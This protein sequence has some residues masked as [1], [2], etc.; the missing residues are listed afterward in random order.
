MQAL[1]VTA[2][3]PHLAMLDVADPVPL[4]D[5]ALVR[6][7]AF[8]L[9]RGEVL[10]LAD[11]V[12][13]A[14]VGWDLTGVVEQAAANGTGPPGGERVVGIVRRGAWA[15][16]AAVPTSR[17]AVIPATVSDAHAASLPTAGRTALRALELGGF[18]LGKRVLVSGATGGVGRYAV[19]L[20]AL[21]GATV[22][23]LV[24][25][26]QTS[27]E[28]LERLG[29]AD[30]VEV[31]NAEFDVAVDAV[32]GSAF[33][34]AIEHVAPAGLVV[35]L[36]TGNPDEVVSFRATHF[37]RAPGARIYTLNLIDELPRMNPTRD[38]ARLL[39]L[40]E[41]RKLE[42]PVELEAPWHEIGRAIDALRSRTI[43]GKAVLRVIPART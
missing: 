22:T 17:L 38:L 27:R 30:V 1:R 16:L 15:E 33:G 31:I 36:A 42:A 21:A 2:Q 24:R 29:A 5:E 13:G 6:V 19:Q 37:D 20:A 18:L 10:D 28:P 11:E 8:S 40:L 23:A 12:E 25:D 43:S 14:A 26:V 9:N 34:A 3:P 41:Q 7:R 4:P 32:G 39:R 35:N